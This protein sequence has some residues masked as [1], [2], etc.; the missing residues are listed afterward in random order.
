MR[1]TDDVNSYEEKID[2]EDDK[3]QTQR[4]LQENRRRKVSV[5]DRCERKDVKFYIITKK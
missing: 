2:L 1:G 4:T 5:K 3:V